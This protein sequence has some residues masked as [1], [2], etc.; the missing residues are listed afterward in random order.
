MGALVAT[1]TQATW[2]FPK[3]LLFLERPFLVHFSL[4]MFNKLKL[5]AKFFVKS[6][7]KL[8]EFARFVLCKKTP[9]V[10]SWDDVYMM[11]EDWCRFL[12]RDFDC[13]IGIPRSGL[14]VADQIALQFGLPLSTPDSF[15]QGAVWQSKRLDLPPNFKRVLV[16]D[17]CVDVGRDLI[18]ELHR[19]RKAFPDCEFLT[20]A[21]ASF[22]RIHLNYC[23]IVGDLLTTGEAPKSFADGTLRPV[24]LRFDDLC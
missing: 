3:L 23:Y 16:V 2:K 14:M 6:H 12:P 1:H 5:K 18:Y 20:G 24:R 4:L 22:G 13:V 21:L 15:I 17:D 11:V 9:V 8:L 7:S 10:L 19:L